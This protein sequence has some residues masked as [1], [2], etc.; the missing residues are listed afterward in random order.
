MAGLGTSVE[1]VAGGRRAPSVLVVPLLSTPKPPL[2]LLSAVDEICDGAVSQVVDAKALGD[3][4]GA[5]THTTTDGK[6]QRVLVVSLGDR[7]KLTAE[8]LRHAAGSIVRWLVSEKVA[9]AGLWL[10]GLQACGVE[11]ALSEFSCGASLA[12]WRYEAMKKALDGAPTK[13]KL[14][15]L[16]SNK[17]QVAKASADLKPGQL[18]AEAVNYSR[19]LAMTPANVINPKTLAAEA[20][21]LATQHKLKYSVIE[22]AKAKQLGMR[23]LLAVGQG[24]KEPGRLIKLEY[25]GAPNSRNSTALVGKAI[26]FDTGGY[27][28]KP[29]PGMVSMKYD[30]CGGCVVLGVMK[31]AALLKLKCNLVALVAAAENMISDN[32]YR[33]GDILEMANGKTVEV[34]NTDAEGRM[35]LAD[36]LWYAEHHCKPTEIIDLATLTGGVIVSL[37]TVCAGLMTPDDDL[38]GALEEAGRRTHERLWRLPLWDDYK[39]LMKGSDSDLV[40]SCAKREAHAIQGGIFLKEFV[41]DKT[42]WA[43]LDIAGMSGDESGGQRE[44]T[45]FGVRLLVDYLSSGGR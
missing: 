43:H 40:N 9:N 13:L 16:G 15:A 11:N 30:K 36:A 28:L 27:S 8:K 44:A 18:L 38:A 25:R 29:T 6:V 17:S 35:V 19:E 1:F 26:T 39:A 10:D 41:T 2:A 12:G 32:A 5:L 42:P 31:A 33:P 3:E 34:T 37:G 4:V 14:A 24:A 7:A 22:G 45:G 23:G 21:K 20:K